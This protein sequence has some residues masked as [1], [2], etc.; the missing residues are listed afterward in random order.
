MCSL[1]AVLRTQGYFLR[2]HRAAHDILDNEANF[3]V[4]AMGGPTTGEREFTAQVMQYLVAHD[5]LVYESSDNVRGMGRAYPDD[6]CKLRDVTPEGLLHMDPSDV[7]RGAIV[8]RAILNFMVLVSGS[9]F[10][11]KLIHY[12]SRLCGFGA[13]C[14]HAVALA[15]RNLFLRVLPA[16]LVASRWTKIGGC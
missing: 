1:A 16:V 10:S 8:L 13:N 6:A 7:V 3:M 15:I 5:G 9:L 4:L 2:L 14:K 11:G 12:H